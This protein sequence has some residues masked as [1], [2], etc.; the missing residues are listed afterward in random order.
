MQI[1]V[2]VSSSPATGPL[3][4]LLGAT[5]AIVAASP[6]PRSAAN[7]L[8][9]SFLRLRDDCT[10]HCGSEKQFCCSSDQVCTTLAGN[11]ATCAPGAGGSYAAYTTTWTETRTYTS[12]IMTNWA[13]AP[14][15]VPGV[16]CKPQSPEQEACGSI[17]CAGWQTCAFKGQCSSR[18]GY[19][20]PSTIVV[21]SNGVVTTRYSAPYRV[22]GTTTIVGSGAR[23]DQ[24]FYTATAT[25]TSAGSTS[26]SD[27]QTIGADGS[28]KGGTGGGLSGGAIAG[29]VI[30]TLAGVALLMLFCF[31]CIARGVWN[32]VFGRKKERTEKIIVEE[33]VRYS[34]HGSQAPPYS[35][36]DRHSGWFGGRPTS[37]ADRRRK[38]SDG[39]WW[40]GLA[41]AATTLLALLNLKKDR[42]PARR[43]QSSRYT[44][45]SYTYSDVTYT[46]PSKSTSRSW[47]LRPS[48]QTLTD[49]QAAPAQTGEPIAPV[50]QAGATAVTAAA[51][52]L[53][54]PVPPRAG[55]RAVLPL[56]FMTN[57]ACVF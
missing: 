32:V 14:T 5:A 49:P 31:C 6:F 38:S 9:L 56:H 19:Q 36:R 27:G 7:D 24:S 25:T 43:P 57:P 21:T 1:H 46:S 40:L 15:P 35:R 47:L 18:P 33:D 54:I 12:T 45:T 20:E 41:G 34:R 29:I 4:L 48:V 22:T 42:K 37:V 39:K 17:C 44:D 26:T 10:T 30:G 8:G 52:P 50:E 3:F 13:P 16:D 28:S 51:E 2:P 11:V 23:S 55:H 53:T